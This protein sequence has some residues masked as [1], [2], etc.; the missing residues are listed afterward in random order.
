M[1]SIYVVIVTYNGIKW[2]DKCFG[3][4]RR[5]DYPLKTIA[6]DNGSTDGTIE[7][8]QTKYPEVEIIQ[9]ESNLGF[10]K[11]NNVGMQ[12]ALDDGADFVFLFNQ[13]AYL[14]KGSLRNLLE[15]FETNSRAGILSPIHF[16]G[17]ERNLDFGFYKYANPQDTPYLLGGLLQNEKPT[18]YESKFINA[19]AWII[20]ANVMRE[21]GFFHPVFEHYNEDREYVMRMQKAN[22]K[23]YV[24]TGMSIVHDR[25]QHRGNNSYFE[26]GEAF[27]RF[28]LLD[29][30]TKKISPTKANVIYLKVLLDKL[31][32]FRFKHALV[33]IKNWIW[34]NNKIRSKEFKEKV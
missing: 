33:T 16:S 19:A 13:D 7:A 6:V 12:K 3:S 18:V 28:L 14:F 2:L 23:V 8:L 21:I 5:A 15:Q 25:E 11:G 4:L 29:L 32:K 34:I 26:M 20:S 31:L 30:V 1:K 17:D 9:P 10:G 24:Y 22:Y 27:K